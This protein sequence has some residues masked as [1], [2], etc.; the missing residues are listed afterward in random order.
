VGVGAAQRLYEG[1]ECDVACQL[2]RNGALKRRACHERRRAIAC[3]KALMRRVA[4]ERRP[5]AR[6]ASGHWL[7][8]SAAQQSQGVPAGEMAGQDGLGRT[9]PDGC[10]WRT[11]DTASL[12]PTAVAEASPC[13]T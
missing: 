7:V 8:D 10:G 3:H 4:S 11:L 2:P 13:Q 1:L 5:R 6:H 9:W 12:D